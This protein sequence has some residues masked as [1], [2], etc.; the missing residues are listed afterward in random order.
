[1]VQLIRREF[2]I[3]IARPSAWA[4]LARV[5]RWPS[6][7]Q[8]IKKVD[9]DPPGELTSHSKGLFRLSNRIKSQ[10]VVTEFDRPRGWKWVGPFLWLTV[11]YDHRFEELTDRKTKLTWIVEADGFGASVF[12]RIFAAVYNANLDRAIPKLIG[13]MEKR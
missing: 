13:E 7:A 8:H 4:H 11:H 12:G 3:N 9:L 6:W 5:E 2:V 10:F 1:M